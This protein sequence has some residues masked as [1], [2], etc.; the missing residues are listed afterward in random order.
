MNIAVVNNSHASIFAFKRL[1]HV[2]YKSGIQITINNDF[3][4]E[5]GIDLALFI[6][7]IAVSSKIKNLNQRI[8]F[9][10]V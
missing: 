8:S 5:T 3:L 9:D 2:R 6:R 1:P 10:A 7:N 4:F